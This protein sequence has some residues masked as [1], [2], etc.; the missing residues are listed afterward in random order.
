MWWTEGS[1]IW[2]PLI[3]VRLTE[4]TGEW[5]PGSAGRLMTSHGWTGG[6]SGPVYKALRVVEATRQEHRWDEEA[7]KRVWSTT[8]ERR[9]YMSSLPAHAERIGTAVRAHW[10]IENRMHGVLDVS[11][12]EDAS[13]IRKRDGP[14]NV[15]VLR[16]IAMN[17]IRQDERAGSLRQKRKRAGWDDEYREQI[18]GL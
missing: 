11:F 2:I 3:P 16:R 14:E 15:S 8:T 10:G 9:Y 13:R 18:L 12:S 5:R 17:M 1:Q 7:G 4:A 6:T